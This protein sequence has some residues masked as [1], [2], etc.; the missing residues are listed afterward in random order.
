MLKT[1]RGKRNFNWLLCIF[2]TSIAASGTF[3]EVHKIHDITLTEKQVQERID[4]KSPFIKNG[5][6]IGEIHTSVGDRSVHLTAKIH[7][8][9]F[10]QTFSAFLE[11]DVISYYD[12]DRG[13]FYLQP[14]SLK[15]NSLEINGDKVST[16]VENLIERFIESEKIQD[17]KNEIG[18]TI[19]DLVNHSISNSTVFTLKQV[20]IYIL[21]DTLKG[22][23]IKLF[24]KSIE[25]KDGKLILHLS[26]WQFTKTALLWI[27]IFLIGFAGVVFLIMNPEWGILFLLVS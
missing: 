24:L 8:K 20:P 6:T 10:G 4:S 27:F 3:Y 16:K 1:K 2:I 13:A 26:V 25:I 18:E 23:A 12:H 7:G 15:I 14:Q 17:N 9:K 21:P 5:I 11:G 19:E 22:S